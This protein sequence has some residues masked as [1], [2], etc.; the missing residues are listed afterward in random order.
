MEKLKNRKI[1]VIISVAVII[2]SVLIGVN[3]SVYAQIKKLNDSF[4]NGVR[5]V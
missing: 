4:E 1:A 5:C 3:K 2:V